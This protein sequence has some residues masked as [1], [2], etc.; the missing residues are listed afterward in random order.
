MP[1]EIYYFLFFFLFIDSYIYYRDDYPYDNN[2]RGRNEMKW[3]EIE[4]NI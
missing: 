3:K 1:Y 2:K 4:Y